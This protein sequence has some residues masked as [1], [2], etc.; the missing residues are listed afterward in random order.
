MN[1]GRKKPRTTAP[2]LPKALK[3]IDKE[4]FVAANR[5]IQDGAIDYFNRFQKVTG[6]IPVAD[7][8][9]LICLY[10]HMA[11]ELERADPIA[12][13]L[14]KTLALIELPPINYTKREK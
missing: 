13:E 14:A 3:T 11:N 6:T 10:R 12:K 5:A 7:A 9:L 1:L 2:Y 8:P 4:D